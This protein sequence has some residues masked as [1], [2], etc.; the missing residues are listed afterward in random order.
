MSDIK[1][2]APFYT[3][4]DAAKELN[5]FLKVDYYD[6]KK[7]LNMALAYNLQ[8]YIF[9][10]GWKGHATYSE[11]MTPEW[12]EYA[13]VNKYGGY[14]SLHSD[15]DA[16]LEAIINA[17]LNL[18]LSEGCLLEVKQ[19]LIKNLILKKEFIGDSTFGYFGNI[20]SIED[21]F[22][23]NPKNY[24]VEVF[25]Q[26]P[27]SDLVR[28]LGKCTL[29]SDVIASVVDIRIAWIELLHEGPSLPNSAV[30]PT[31]V[32]DSTIEKEGQP[33]IYQAIHRTDILITHYQLSRIIEGILLLRNLPVETIET[34]IEKQDQRPRGKSQAKINAQLAA[35]TLASYLWKK[36]VNNS[37][38][39]REMSMLVYTELYE[40]EHRDQLPDMPDTLKSWIKEVAPQYAREAGRT[41]GS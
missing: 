38:K 18:F 26:R 12:D 25:K 8:L 1:N 20:L 27:S 6:T 24:F 35:K 41:K 32:I 33:T 17:R 9:V 34:L 36:D 5:R 23:E 7:L 31:P 28:E 13:D 15:M 4:K 10:K 29:V 19:E 11:E 39:I 22:I 16:T 21:S 3:L 30:T 14:T 2:P 40:T 37:I